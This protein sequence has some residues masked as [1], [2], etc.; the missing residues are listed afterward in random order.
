M[1]STSI[2]K[3]ENYEAQFITQNETSMFCLA[4]LLSCQ[5]GAEEQNGTTTSVHEY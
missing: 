3:L 1:G 2:K 4:I 5:G